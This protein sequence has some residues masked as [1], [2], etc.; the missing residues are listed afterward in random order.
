MND[1][2]RRAMFA[3]GA[4]PT[5]DKYYGQVDNSIN[6]RCQKCGTLS[7][8]LSDFYAHK[9]THPNFE[10]EHHYKISAELRNNSQYRLRKHHKLGSHKTHCDN[11]N[12]N[13][14]MSHL[15]NYKGKSYKPFS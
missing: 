5:K 3:K 4:E 13:C 11:S 14:Q 10:K 15:G 9:K 6:Y 8:S 7:D 12:K 1:K 2:S